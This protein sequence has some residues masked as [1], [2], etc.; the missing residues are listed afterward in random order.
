[1][2]VNEPRSL[3]ACLC[4]YR[5]RV[6]PP[7]P[8]VTHGPSLPPPVSLA[9]IIDAAV[10]YGTCKKDI[11][12][13]VYAD[14][15]AIKD[16]E[17]A[18]LQAAQDAADGTTDMQT[19]QRH[20]AAAATQETLIDD[21]SEGEGGAAAE[22]EEEGGAAAEEEEEGGAAAEEEEEEGDASVLGKRARP[23]G[24]VKT[25]ETVVL[26]R[27]SWSDLNAR[28]NEYQAFIEAKN[29][30][31]LFAKFQS[32][33]AGEME[34]DEEQYEQG[35]DEEEEDEDEEYVPDGDGSDNG[36]GKA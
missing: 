29:L 4:V 18:A 3:C 22:E 27:E 13:A 32:E 12:R 15:Q 24:A 19:V 28:V 35:A 17:N 14:R 33:R 20:Q 34:L 25:G 31:K 1:M 23:S 8:R 11:E 10:Q 16:E 36:K 21:L 7:S 30:Q 26:H 9:A 6:T 2:Y 5:A